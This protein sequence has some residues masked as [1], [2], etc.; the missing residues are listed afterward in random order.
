DLADE[1]LAL[2][3]E[4]PL[5]Q[6]IDDGPVEVFGRFG[7]DDLDLGDVALLVDKDV[8]DDHAAFDALHD[9]LLRIDRI[10]LGDRGDA[11]AYRWLR[12]RWWRGRWRDHRRCRWRRRRHRG[13]HRLG[14]GHRRGYVR[15]RNIRLLRRRR[16][17]REL[18]L[19]GRRRRRR[20]NLD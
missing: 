11:L 9:R 14:L 6:R 10:D 5:H 1:L 18:D 19:L 15:R 4:L 20:R 3:R 8:G 7:L 13:D 16:R 2:A 12:W 17:F